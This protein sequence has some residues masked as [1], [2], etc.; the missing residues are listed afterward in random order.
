VLLILKGPKLCASARRRTFCLVQFILL[1]VF[2]VSV[3]GCCDKSQ[4]PDYTRSLYSDAPRDRSNAALQLAR[5]GSNASGAVARLTQLLYDENVGVQSSAAYALR[6][7]DTKDARAA[8][9]RAEAAR[10]SR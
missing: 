7:I 5:C 2:L 4:I 1:T 10:R 6:K 9:E 8:M 3:V